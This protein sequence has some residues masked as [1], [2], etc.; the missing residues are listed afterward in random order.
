MTEDSLTFHKK[1]RRVIRA[2]LTKLGTKLTELEA[3][4]DS[5]NLLESA[6][7]LADKLKTLQQEYRN[8]QLSIIDHTEEEEELA[9]EQ[10]ALDDNDDLTSLLSIHIQRLIISA[11]PSPNLDT[12][13]IAAKQ[14]TLLQ[15]LHFN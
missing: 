1:R 10:Q 5:P 7:N 15:D 11:T 2:S 3:N 12:V 14:I 8:H 6:S 9:E 13:R 4:R